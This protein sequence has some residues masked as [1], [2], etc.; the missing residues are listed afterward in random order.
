MPLR[1][2]GDRIIVKRHIEDEKVSEGGVVLPMSFDTANL[3]GTIVSVGPGGV[4][5]SK[6]RVS[7][8]VKV[9]DH[10]RYVHG[11]GVIEDGREKYDVINEYHILGVEE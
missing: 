8:D 7:P 3:C 4:T 11:I 9:G 5:Y 10:I 1:A 2:V 6:D